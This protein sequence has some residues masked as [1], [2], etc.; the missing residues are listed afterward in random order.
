[1]ALSEW[2]NNREIRGR[3]AF[4]LEEAC[5][6]QQDVDN[7]YV[8]VGLSRLVSRARV[9]NVYRG[10]YVI[11]PPQYALKGVIPAPYYID[12][13]MK[14]IGKPYY[15]GLLTAAALHGATHQRA[16]ATQV[17]TCPPRSTISDKNKQI[18]WYYRKEIPAELLLSTNTE[19]G[20]MYYSCAELTAIDLVQFASHTGGYQRVATVLAEMIDAVEINKIERVLPYTNYA[21]VQRLGF[22]LEHVLHEQ[23]KADLLYSIVK[24]DKRKWHLTRMSNDHPSVECPTNRWRI[25]MNID[26][27]ID[28]I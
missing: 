19:T 7:N 14:Y 1:M 15:V 11:V 17:M 5:D 23:E 22:I 18:S 6:A 12:A 24:K 13:L 21:V 28:E 4:G 8:H 25:N 10:F 2:V 16:M 3:V 27:E 20:V 9:Q 26:I